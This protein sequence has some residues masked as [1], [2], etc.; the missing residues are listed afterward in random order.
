MVTKNGLKYTNVNKKWPQIC[1]CIPKVTSNIQ[2]LPKMT[3]NIEVKKFW[4]R[5]GEAEERSRWE[6]AGGRW[7]F[8]LFLIFLIFFSFYKKIF[9]CNM[10][11][12]FEMMFFWWQYW[13]WLWVWYCH[14]GQ[15]G[16]YQSD[17]CDLGKLVFDQW[18]QCVEWKFESTSLINV[19]ADTVTWTEEK[20]E[21]KDYRSSNVF[22][23]LLWKLCL[24]IYIWRNSEAQ[25]RL[26]T[27]AKRMLGRSKRTRKLEECKID[28]FCK[29]TRTNSWAISET[30]KCSN[31]VPLYTTMIFF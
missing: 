11:I 5:E 17:K 31:K 28:Q 27:E 22:M 3:P 21:M 4:S 23:W 12:C 19:A 6:G 14:R 13:C 7:S 2:M 10:V 26:H 29:Q 8:Y 15:N 1:K 16:G 20:R 18:W 25:S 24:E 9:I 30:N